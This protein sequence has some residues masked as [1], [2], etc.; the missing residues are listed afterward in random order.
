MLR[1]WRKLHLGGDAS[2]ERIVASLLT[3]RDVDDGSQVS[4]LLDRVGESLVSFTGD[5]AYDQGGVITSIGSRHPDTGIVVPPRSTAVPS[6][7][8]EDVPMQRN[9]HLRAITERD[10]MVWQAASGYT[11]RAR[12]E[13]AMSRFKR[14]IGDA[15]RSHADKRRTT[16]VEVAV[17]VLNRMLDLGRPNSVS[18]A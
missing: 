12:A 16:E 2:T 4:A 9:R 13:T 3:T 5:D 7:T 15:L 1:L 14:V 6:E 18:I 17:Y 8:A 11:R 10:R